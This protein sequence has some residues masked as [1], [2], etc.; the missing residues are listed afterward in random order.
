MK[1]E[2]FYQRVSRYLTDF[3]YDSDSESYVHWTKEDLFG[4]YKLAVSLVASL[5]KSKF[6]TTVKVPLQE[7]SIQT[8]PPS[9]NELSSVVGAVDSSGKLIEL[10]RRVQSAMM[11]RFK[12]ETCS[13]KLDTD[14][15][16]NLES[17]DY[18][19][20]SKNI[21]EVYPPV[22]AE[23]QATLLVTCFTPPK[24]TSESEEV[25]G[26]DEYEA[27]IFELMLY[28]AW[29][30][31]TESTASRDRSNTHWANAMSLIPAILQTN[32]TKKVAK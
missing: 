31:D 18:I 11:S 15:T 32:I 6:V 30:V 21:I 25:Y 19:D 24:I 23:T 1:A 3:D 9:C 29:G 10:T 22:P 7:G 5:N 8:I 14:G 28:Y 17:W 12:L 26:L 13:S 20:G 4:Y 2:D 27:A 16:Y